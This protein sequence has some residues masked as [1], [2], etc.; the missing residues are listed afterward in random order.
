[1]LAL[2]VLALRLVDATII[3]PDGTVIQRFDWPGGDQ[4]FVT[5]QGTVNLYDWG[6]SNGVRTQPEGDEED[7]K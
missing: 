6:D 5:P 4:S 3:T 1:M 7:G 2:L